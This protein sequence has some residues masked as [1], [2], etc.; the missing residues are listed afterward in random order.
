MPACVEVSTVS[1]KEEVPQ[2]RPSNGKSRTRGTHNVEVPQSERPGAAGAGR[3]QLSGQR[4][5]MNEVVITAALRTAVGKFNGSLAKGPASVLGAQITKA[6]L[7][8]TGV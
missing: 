1:L 3:L 6:R 7:A 4:E 5:Y 2:W 8:S